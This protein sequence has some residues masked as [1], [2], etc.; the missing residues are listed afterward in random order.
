MKLHDVFLAGVLRENPLFVMVLG[1]CSALA[2]TT[3]LVQ[4]VTLWAIVL[5]TA[6]IS[7]TCIS[8]LRSRIPHDF[9]LMISM[10]IVATAVI[11]AET[12]LK[13]TFPAVARQ[14][15]PYVGLVIT[16]CIILGRIERFA[17]HHRPLPAAV[18]ALG[19]SCGYGLVLVLLAAVREAFGFG[20]LFG[21]QFAPAAF[22]PCAFLVSPAG[23]FL[24]FATVLLIVNSVRRREAVHD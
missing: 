21:I 3:M 18:D 19:V 8:L 7:S 13:V 4:A 6:V 20:T 23:G 17:L 15:G 10:M 1:L 11:L 22:L 2:V 12:I 16:N 14:L 5:W 9:R 24:V